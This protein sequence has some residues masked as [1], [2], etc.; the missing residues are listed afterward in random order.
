MSG[1]KMEVI[2][3]LFKRLFC[4]HTAADLLSWHWTHGPNGNDPLF[5][6]AEYRCN[7]C[8]KIIYL[9]KRGKEAHDWAK[10]TKVM[11]DYKKA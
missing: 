11:G 1:E 6:Q 5:I 7:E 3:V 4:K 10:V 9:Y 2:K 8:G